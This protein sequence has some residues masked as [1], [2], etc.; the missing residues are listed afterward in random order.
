MELLCIVIIVALFV[1]QVIY[2]VYKA[3]NCLTKD[4]SLSSRVCTGVAFGVCLCLIIYNSL[5]IVPPDTWQLRSLQGEPFTIASLAGLAFIWCVFV[6][7]LGGVLT[8]LQYIGLLIAHFKKVRLCKN[9][10]A[11][12][13]LPGGETSVWVSFGAMGTFAAYNLMLYTFGMSDW[14]IVEFFR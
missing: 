10:F 5:Q 6:V 7:W 13:T 2:T 4:S 12:P 11:G 1:L 9:R 3:R 14:L 8:T